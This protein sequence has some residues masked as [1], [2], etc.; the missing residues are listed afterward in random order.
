MADAEGRPPT[1]A[2][3]LAALT[4][5][6]WQPRRGKVERHR[7]DAGPHVA[8]LPPA[9]LATAWALPTLTERAEWY[10]EGNGFRRRPL[11]STAEP[12]P[13][14]LADVVAELRAELVALPELDDAREPYQHLRLFVA[15]AGPAL[16]DDYLTRLARAVRAQLGRVPRPERAT[17]TSEERAARIRESKAAHQRRVRAEVREGGRDDMVTAAGWVSAWRE[18]VSPGAHPATAVYGTYVDRVADAGRTPVGRN[19]FY[20]IADEVCG[21]RKRRARGPA[22]VVSQEV[23]P[24]NREQRKELASLI[25]DRL[26]D[27]WRSAALDGLADLLADRQGEKSAA[28][29]P[30]IEGAA[31]VVSLDARRARRVA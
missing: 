5:R 21:P 29:R 27:E 14:D 26:T 10:G 1:P 25:V 16:V 20:R 17:L 7:L 2:A 9:T 4:E 24:M 8:L 23:A 30:A 13:V 15:A 28:T 22:Y 18:Q 19:T 3:R 12:A 31:N 11:G 6:S